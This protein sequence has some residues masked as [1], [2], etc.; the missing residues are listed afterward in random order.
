TTGVFQIPVECAACDCKGEQDLFKKMGAGPNTYC[1]PDCYPDNSCR[2]LVDFKVE[3]S[4]DETYQAAQGTLTLKDGKKYDSCVKNGNLSLTEKGAAPALPGSATLMPFA[5]TV[6]PEICDGIDND[7]NGKI[8]DDPVDCPPM[9]CDNLGVC[10]GI[11]PACTG[12]WT[13]D[14]TAVKREQPDE[15]TCDGLDNDCDGQVDEKLIGCFEKCDGLDNDNNGTVDDKAQDSPCA[16]SLGVCATGASGTCLGA[17][18]W[19]CDA[20]S[21]DFEA[22]ETSCDGKD[23]DCDGQVDEGCS[24]P[25]GKSQMFVVHWGTTPEL[26]RADLDGKNA[27][28][29]AALS[30]FALTKVVLDTKANK[31]YYGDASD[32]IYRANLDGSGIEVMWNGKAQTWDVNPATGLII[33]EC[34]TS[35]VCK[36]TSPKATSILVQPA[37][38]ANLDIDPV[39]RFVYWADYASGANYHIRRAG[40]DGG[41]VTEVVTDVQAALMVKVDPAGQ[42]L[43]WPNGLGIYQSHLDGTNEHLFLSLPSSYTYD[44]AFDTNGGKLYF[45]DVNVS[46]VRR[47]GLDGKGFET[48]IQNVTYPISIGLYLCP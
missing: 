10:K 11:K 5:S 23:N 6:T 14:Y 39:N 42:R 30:G 12:S 29:V 32:N 22:V 9:P 43:Y 18:G 48:L 41:N 26:I 47:V 38:V 44:M 46:E 3:V 35:F 25:F 8:D 7:K 21:A 13:C 45:T 36:L 16:A 33:G 37:S 4:E 28:P 2:C 20:A 24:C 15:T 1:Y 27:Q 19:R 40:F 31:L 17:A 34:N